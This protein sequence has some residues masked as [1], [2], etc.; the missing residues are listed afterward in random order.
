MSKTKEHSADVLNLTFDI[1]SKVVH[2]E[3]K[4]NCISDSIQ[5]LIDQEVAKAKR[6]ERI[7]TLEEVREIAHD[8]CNWATTA[9]IDI[10]LSQL[11]KEG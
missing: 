8:N 1:I 6:E 4:D 9:R 7:K 5:A 10:F 11:K 2:K 3:I